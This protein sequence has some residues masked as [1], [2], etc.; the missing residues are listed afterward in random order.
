MAIKF[1]E[2]VKGLL[3]RGEASDPTDNENGSIWYNSTSNLLKGYVESAVRTL[4]TTDQTQT[5]TNADR[6][7][8]TINLLRFL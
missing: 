4:V 8:E 6:D 1:R 7:W 3:F 2:I 5:L